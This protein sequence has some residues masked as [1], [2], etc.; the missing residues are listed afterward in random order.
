MHKVIGVGETILDILFQNGQPVAAVP[1]GSCFNSII[2]LGRTG[3][4]CLFSGYSGNDRPGQQTRDML[5]ENG[6]DATYF[7]LRDTEKSAL[8]LAYLSAKG[9]ADYLFYKTQ[10]TLGDDWQWPVMEAGDVLLLGS[11][12]AICDTTHKQILRLLKQAKEAGATVYY[13]QNFRR[14]HQHELE[15]LM[16]AILQNFAY[17]T[18]VRGSADDFEI[19]YGTRDAEAIYRQH[20]APHCPLF[21]CTAGESMVSVHTPQ[22]SLQ[23]QAPRIDDV[24]STVGAGDNFNAGFVFALLQRGLSANDILQMPPQ[25]WQP[26]VETAM[27]FAGEACR[28]HN[29]YVSREFAEK[30][31]NAHSTNN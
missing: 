2:S 7:Q 25:Q 9:D 18:I 28:S 27:A 21:I 8:S 30:Q 3:V 6:I 15:A 13:D 4:P 10:P 23:M 1:G 14:S 26:L 22:G 19:M 29:N 16:P 31:R 24:V 12:F 5:Q 20:I 17:S 11:Y